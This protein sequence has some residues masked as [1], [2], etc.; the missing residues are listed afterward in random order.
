MPLAEETGLAVPIGAW[1]LEQ[2]C[3]QARRWRDDPERDT[4]VVSVNLSCRE[5]EQPDIVAIIDAALWHSGIEPNLLRLEITESVIVQEVTAA[6]QTLHRIKD[7]GVQIAID[8]FGIGYSS[9]A[10][11]ARLNANTM[12]VDRSFVALLDS[13]PRLPDIFS[14]I[15]SLAHALDMDVVAEGVESAAQFDAV[16]RAGCDHAQGFFIAQPVAL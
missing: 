8:D 7:L 12:K 3:Q 2:A 1:V 14:A 11:L 13:D 9:L 6:R 16:R 10:Y 5:L 15:V 4:V